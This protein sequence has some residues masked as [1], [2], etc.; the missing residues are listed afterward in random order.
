MTKRTLQNLLQLNGRV[1]I[2]VDNANVL[3]KIGTVLL[4]RAVTSSP[5]TNRT[6]T[7]TSSSTNSDVRLYLY[8]STESS[9]SSSD[10]FSTEFATMKDSL[11]RSVYDDDYLKKFSESLET[12]LTASE[13]LSSTQKVATFD[14]LVK[15][16]PK[17]KSYI[18]NKGFR[19]GREHGVEE[20]ISAVKDCRSTALTGLQKY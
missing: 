12:I 18:Y 3:Q 7:N 14:A 17:L 15:S 4:S 19:D 2:V 20:A 16:Y 11:Q 1:D 8:E 10:S 5:I 9:S 13:S 6:N